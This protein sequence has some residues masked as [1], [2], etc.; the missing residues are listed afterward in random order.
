MQTIENSG[1]IDALVKGC[2]LTIGNFDGFHQG[3]K[4]II[5][6]ARRA[7]EN[8]GNCSVAAMTFDPHPVAILHPERTLQVLTPLPL[9]KALLASAGVDYLIVVKDSYKLLT[10]SP[11]DFIEEFL[12]K[13][14]AP[15]ALIEGDDFHFGYGRSGNAQM[16]CRLGKQKGFEVFIVDDEEMNLDDSFVRISS[17]LIRHLLHNSG[18]ADAARAIGRPYRLMGKVVKGR[19]K[20]LQLGFPTANIEPH[21]QIIPAEGVYAGFVSVAENVEEIC[22]MNQKIPAVFSLGRAKT[23]ISNHPLLIEAHI[24]DEKINGLYDKFLTMDFIDFVRHQRRFETE[25]KLKEQIK[26]DCERAKSIL[27]A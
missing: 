17:T 16:L 20:G 6:S 5:A 21:D 3:H 9:K 1:K 2:C 12:V 23:F 4:K 18:V 19:G 15:K 13:S 22:T 26:K 27:M 24:L 8:L 25:E 11:N 14:I 10:L 7:A